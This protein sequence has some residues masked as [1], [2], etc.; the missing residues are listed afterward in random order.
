MN[1]TGV[2]RGRLDEVK[3]EPTRG[4]DVRQHQSGEQTRALRV[5][6]HVALLAWAT[7]LLIAVSLPGRN[8]PP[9]TVKLTSTA[10]PARR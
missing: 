4:P 8:P 9:P 6:I 1:C 3:A 5:R 7:I 2:D 10:L